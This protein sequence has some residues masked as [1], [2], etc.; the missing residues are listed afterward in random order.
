MKNYEF[1]N[2]VLKTEN[3]D[4]EGISTRLNNTS[5]IRLLH[6]SMGLVT[7]ASEIEDVLKKHIYYGKVI[8]KVNLKEEIGDVFYYLGVLCDQLG[9][10]FE[11]C[12][13][14]NTDKLKARYGDK[15]SSD[16]AISRDLDVERKILE[17]K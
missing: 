5:T 13:Q 12:M 7:E 14:T 15:F 17:N 16:S 1:I 6:G 2:G 11:E 10:T 3:N 8:D 4:F 9:I